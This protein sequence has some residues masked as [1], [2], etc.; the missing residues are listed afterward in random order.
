[1]ELQTQE[2]TAGALVVDSLPF[3]LGG[4]A[5][6]ARALRAE[7]VDCLVGY[8]GGINAARVEALTEAGIAFM[9]VT[10]GMVSEH[11]NGPATVSQCQKLELPAG[12]SVWLDMEGLKVF[13]TDPGLLMER[14]NAWALDVEKAGF[15][16]CLYVGVPQPLTGAELYSM[17][18]VRY[19]HGQGQVRDRHNTFANPDCGW[20]MQQKWP[21][22]RR[23]GL[24]VDDNTIAPDNQGRLPA[25][26]VA[27]C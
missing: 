2:A 18:H 21:S 12:C 7:G 4:N 5:A 13:H 11:W 19:W 9:P 3:S 8:L 23:G 15:M 20:C 24:L 1:M 22:L 14:A 25:W 10:Y 27:A 17:R 26:V 16:P 6:I